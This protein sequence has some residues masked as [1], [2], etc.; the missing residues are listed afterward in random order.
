MDVFP[1]RVVLAGLPNRLHPLVFVSRLTDH[2]LLLAVDRRSDF[3]DA[4]GAQE[5]HL[6]VQKNSNAGSDEHGITFKGIDIPQAGRFVEG[7]L[8][9]KERR[10]N[11]AQVRVRVV[12]GHREEVVVEFGRL[13][14]QGLQ[15][16][17]VCRG[18]GASVI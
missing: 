12:L 14:R 1:L 16:K 10:E 5:L 13:R 2:A 6:V 9:G 15:Q 7:Q 11:I 8:V 3:F 4:L 17:V 18:L